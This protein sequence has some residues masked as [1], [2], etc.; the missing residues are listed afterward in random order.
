MTRNS[1]FYNGT[2]AT[3]KAKIE[4]PKVKFFIALW[5]EIEGDI[6][7]RSAIKFIGTSCGVIDSML[8][9]RNLTCDTGEKI[10]TAYNELKDK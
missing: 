7:Y 1:K 9:E 6:G 2:N 5:R 10:L 3:F 4:K 8:N